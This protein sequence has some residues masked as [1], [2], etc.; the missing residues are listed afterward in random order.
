MGMAANPSNRT[1]PVRST[2]PVRIRRQAIGE[3][4]LPRRAS[5]S[6]PTAKFRNIK[7][8]EHPL[9]ALFPVGGTTLKPNLA[10]AQHGSNRST[11]YKPRLRKVRGG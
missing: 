3:L 8:E 10:R 4:A 1:L 2:D 5:E 9:R 6:S 7:I 11:V